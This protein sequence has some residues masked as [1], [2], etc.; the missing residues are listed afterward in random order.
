MNNIREQI[1]KQ[2]IPDKLVVFTFDDA[3][4]SHA[5][6]VVPILRKYGFGATFFICEFPANKG[7]VPCPGFEDKEALSY[8]SNN[9]RSFK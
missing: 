4:L 5:T 2:P 7:E 3:S 9:T 1:I 8:R 6:F